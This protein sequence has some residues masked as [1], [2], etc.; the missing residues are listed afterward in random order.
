MVSLICP[1]KT[2]ALLVS[3]F[4]FIYNPS[5]RHTA[6]L[7]RR[8]SQR[9]SFRL[10]SSPWPCSRTHPP[11]TRSAHLMMPSIWSPA[12]RPSRL[13]HCSQHTCQL[14]IPPASHSLPSWLS[15]STHTS[16]PP[17]HAPFKVTALQSPVL[18][19]PYLPLLT[20][21]LFPLEPSIGHVSQKHCHAPGGPDKSLSVPMNAPWSKPP[22]S[23]PSRF[24]LSA[25]TTLVQS[26]VTACLHSCGSS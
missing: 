6:E 7:L 5:A 3:H 2:K 13:L 14:A 23:Q 15:H 22:Y 1:N 20:G 8:A 21:D 24:F 17:P 18:G 12:H 25:A 26:P 16:V 10:L 4:P 11:S 19:P 9:C